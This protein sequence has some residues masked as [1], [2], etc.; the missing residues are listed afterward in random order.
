MVK[1]Q[2]SVEKLIN[3]YIEKTGRNKIDNSE[4]YLFIGHSSNGLN[5]K[6]LNPNTLNLMIKKTCK[7]AGINKK[8]KV[9]STRHTAITLA[10]TAG[11]SIEKV[12]DFA[13]HKNLATT[14]RYVHSI[15]KLRN[16]ASDFIDIV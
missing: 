10:I 16:N 14:N 2:P 8:L 15:D 13:A 5:G 12:R 1:L 6:K 9:H 4:E 3:E 11:A 7:K